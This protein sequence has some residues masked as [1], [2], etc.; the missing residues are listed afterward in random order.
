MKL[1]ILFYPDKRLNQVA[2][3]IQEV[4]EKVVQLADDMIETMYAANGVG[5]AAVQVGVALRL[6]VIDVSQTRNEPLVLINPRIVEHSETPVMNEEGCLSVPDI[7][8]QVQRWD[9]VVV[10]ALDKRGQTFRIEAKDLVDGLLCRCLQ[11]EIDHLDGHV[12]VEYLST[13][14]RNRIRTKMLKR[15]REKN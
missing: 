13:L 9:W 1:E 2:L 4:N 5:L 3:P 10:E 15:M 6:V 12:F 11:H 8:D 7:Y 14:K